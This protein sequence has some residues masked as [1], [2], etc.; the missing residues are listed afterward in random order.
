M[1]DRPKPE[2]EGKGEG[3]GKPGTLEA[4]PRGVVIDQGVRVDGGRGGGRG[5]KRGGKERGRGLEVRGQDVHAAAGSGTA[6]LH[7]G[8]PVVRG[9]ANQGVRG[10][11][12]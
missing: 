3:R 8:L 6:I 9:P 10:R 12:R 2:V 1:D 11:R 4:Q 5:R 7:P